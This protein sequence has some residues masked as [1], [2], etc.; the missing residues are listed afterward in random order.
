MEKKK[1]KAIDK[2]TTEILI[3]LSNFR[4]NRAVG[5]RRG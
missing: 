3:G 4:F 1:E 2:T 5:C